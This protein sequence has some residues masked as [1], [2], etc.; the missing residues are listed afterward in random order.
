[1]DEI[2]VPDERIAL[3]G[4]EVRRIEHRR[5]EAALFR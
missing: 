2:V 4:E 3:L 1:M 5:T